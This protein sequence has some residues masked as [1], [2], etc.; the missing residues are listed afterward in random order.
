MEKLTFEQVR[1]MEKKKELH[2]LVL[3]PEAS[4]TVGEALGLNVKEGDELHLFHISKT[5]APKKAEE[6]A[7]VGEQPQQQEVPAGQVDPATGQVVN[8]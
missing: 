7:P 8:G 4:V 3:T 5:D 6:A 1:Y 2:K